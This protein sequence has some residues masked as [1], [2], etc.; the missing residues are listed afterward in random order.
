MEITVPSATEPSL[1]P[2]GQHVLSAHVM[3]VPYQA[4]NGWS[5]AARDEVGE[6]GL[7]AGFGSEEDAEG[8][9]ELDLRLLAEVVVVRAAACSSDG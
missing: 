8:S 9:E 7:V 3:Y 5:D 6:E 4:R 1:A 2:D